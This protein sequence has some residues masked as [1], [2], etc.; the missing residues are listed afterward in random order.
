[1]QPNMMTGEK[2]DE[3]SRPL[4]KDGCRQTSKVSRGRKTPRT[5]ENGKATAEMRGL[6]EEEYEKIGGG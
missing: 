3:V 4:G 5:Q 2:P 1:M 6:R